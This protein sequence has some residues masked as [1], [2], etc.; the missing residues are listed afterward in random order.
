M[1]FGTW[2]RS[3]GPVGRAELLLEAMMRWS[4]HAWA[5]TS[6][7]VRTP[8]AMNDRLWRLLIMFLNESSFY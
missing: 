8:A 7:T 5:K 6:L 4:E 1:H 3:S 2:W